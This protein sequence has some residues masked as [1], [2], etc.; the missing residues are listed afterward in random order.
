MAQ[1]DV[2]VRFIGKH[3]AGIFVHHLTQMRERLRVLSLVVIADPDLVKSIR[4]DRLIF[5]L[6]KFQQVFDRFIILFLRDKIF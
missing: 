3:T 4:L 6:L 2:V 1:P 5:H